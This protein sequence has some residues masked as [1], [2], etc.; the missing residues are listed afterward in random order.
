MKNNDELLQKRQEHSC[1]DKSATLFEMLARR[2]ILDDDSIDDELIRKAQKAKRRN[3]YHNTQMLLQNYRN[4]AWALECFPAQIADELERPMEDLDSILS[5][6]NAEMGMGNVKLENR[7][8]SIQRSRL[9]MDRINEAISIL[10]KKPGNGR[11]MYDIVYHT[12]LGPEVLSH[13][14]ILYRCDIS[15]RHYYRLRQQAVNIISMRLWS[16]PGKELDSWLEV[17]SL[18]EEME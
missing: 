2:G 7:L 12:W 17:M 13:T 18:L 1:D 5:L 15:T 8:L 16:A 3:S 4:I 11:Q 6:V 9:M 10:K 14:E